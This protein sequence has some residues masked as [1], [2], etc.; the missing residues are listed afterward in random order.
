MYLHVF[1]IR[2][3]DIIHVISDFTFILSGKMT[4]FGT[5]RQT[6]CPICCSKLQAVSLSLSIQFESIQNIIFWGATKNKPMQ[7]F[8]KTYTGKRPVLEVESDSSVKD[9]KK[10]VW[11]KEGIPPEQ[12]LL[13]FAGKLGKDMVKHTRISLGIKS[14]IHLKYLHVPI[15]LMKIS[16]ENVGKCIIVHGSDGKCD[17]KLA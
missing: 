2:R 6:S 5:N 4:L 1:I 10:Q 11:E 15:D 14:G 16:N 13:W 12:Q 8:I 7:I 9:V 17:G 3:K